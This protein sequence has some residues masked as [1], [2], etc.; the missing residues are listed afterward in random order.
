MSRSRPLLWSLIL[1]L[2]LLIIRMLSSPGV[3]TWFKGSLPLTLHLL[4]YRTLTSIPGP[5]DIEACYPER[6][7]FISSQADRSGPQTPGAIYLLDPEQQ[8]NICRRLDT[9]YPPD[10]HPHGMS[11]LYTN[12]IVTLYVISHRAP[13]SSFLEVFQ[14]ARTNSSVRLSHVYSTGIISAGQPNDLRVLDDGTLVISHDQLKGRSLYPALLFNIRTAPLTYYDG[15][16]FYPLP[17]RAV[18]GNGIVHRQEKGKTIL[19][20]ADTGGRCLDKIELYFDKGRV[21]TRLLQRIALPAAPDNLSLDP[22]GN[23]YIAC[24]YS[25]SLFMAHARDPQLPAPSLVYR[26]DTS[27]TLHLVYADPGREIPAASVAV[28]FDNTL[29]LGQVFGDFVLAGELP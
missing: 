27:N 14:A 26:L 23:I 3:V 1:V 28:P 15:R 29:Y 6:L 5:E 13:G 11:L 10:F 18:M 16:R 24:H 2:L 7:L 21:S 22:E 20:R 4:D 19:Y 25:F 8:S 12:G 9:D 17:H